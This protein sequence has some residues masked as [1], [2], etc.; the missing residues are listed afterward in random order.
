MTDASESAAG[1]PRGLDNVTEQSV[2]DIIVF[3]HRS[4]APNPQKIQAGITLTPL[5]S[6]CS[7]LPNHIYPHWQ[8]WL[9]QRQ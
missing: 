3:I 2:A 6:A 8:V 7:T 4:N 1:V 9:L 5:N